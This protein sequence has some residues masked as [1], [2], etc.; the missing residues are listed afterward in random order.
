MKYRVVIEYTRDFDATSMEEA[1]QIARAIHDVKLQDAGWRRHRHRVEPVTDR[2]LRVHV[3]RRRLADGSYRTHYYAWRGKGAPRLDGE[4]GS[5]EFIA[6]Y[7][8]AM[9]QHGYPLSRSKHLKLKRSRN[10][11]A[12]SSGRNGSQVDKNDSAT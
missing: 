9:V 10:L 11:T 1:K 8:R 12:Q 5:P 2:V 3:M 7:E 4:P 6:S